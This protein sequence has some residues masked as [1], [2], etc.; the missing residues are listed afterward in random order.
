MSNDSAS[1]RDRNP[2]AEQMGDE[3]MARNLAHQADA[4][5][6]Q[7]QRLFDRYD[8]PDER[9]ENWLRTPNDP[10]LGLST[11]PAKERLHLFRTQRLLIWA[12]WM[13]PS[14]D[15]D[16]AEPDLKFEFKDDEFAEAPC[17]ATNEPEQMP[18]GVIPGVVP[19]AASTNT[20]A[21]PATYSSLLPF[22]KDEPR[23]SP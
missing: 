13:L 23:V 11:L 3:S 8:L 22:L 7:E 4:I 15:M 21:P 17:Y 16:K 10:V 20:I 5:W 9:T 2:Q 6:P 12:V 14:A 19:N 1:D 18:P